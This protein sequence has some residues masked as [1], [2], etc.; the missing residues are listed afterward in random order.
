MQ[1][2]KV[3]SSVVLRSLHERKALPVFPAVI[4]KLDEVLA[5]AHVNV[6][7]VVA[8]VSA[9]M[10]IASGIMRAASSVRYGMKPPK[11]LL[12]AVSRLGFAEVRAVAFAVSYTAGFM[13]PKHIDIAIFWRHAF[14][15]A[16]AA[17]ELASWFLRMKQQRVCDA[18]T[19]F[20]LGLSHEV[21]VLLLDL[22]N[23]NEFEQV[24]AGVAHE[25]QSMLEQRALGTTHA[26]IGAALLKQW[27]FADYMAMA[28]AA[29][30]FPA[31]LQP[32]LQ[33]LADV[34]LFAE[35]IA[36]K[37]GFTNGVYTATSVGMQDLVSARVRV[38]DISEATLITLSESVSEHLQTEGWL[39]LADSLQ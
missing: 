37:L 28:V 34:V 1:V 22:F 15:S 8:I 11:D 2:A 39:E 13:K 4:T 33:P 24:L 6:D 27:G 19:A 16:V 23:P 12:D 7:Q 29:H 35:Y 31:R 21:G 25:E 5:Q 26:I 36:A 14:A 3:S 18:P 32:E 17:R 38:Y 20:L 30:H 10:V 9:D